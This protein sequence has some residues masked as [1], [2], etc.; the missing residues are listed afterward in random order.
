MKSYILFI[1]LLAPFCAG[2]Q[3]ND[4]IGFSK[5]YRYQGDM[6]KRADLITCLTYD[7]ADNDLFF[8][9]T[10]LNYDPGQWH[11]LTDCF[12]TDAEGHVLAEWVDSSSAYSIGYTAVAM[13]A[14]GQSV[15]WG[16]QRS[17]GYITMVLTKTDKN[18]N[19]IWQKTYPTTVT[20]GYNSSVIQDPKSGDIYMLESQWTDAGSNYPQADNKVY[21]IKTDSMGNLLAEGTPG[22][23]G[24]DN[25]ESMVRTDDGNFLVSGITWGAG[26]G[27]GQEGSPF[28]MKVD[29]EGN[30]LWHH[31]Y[32]ANDYTAWIMHNA[33]AGDGN[34]INVGAV[35]PVHSITSHSFYGNS[36][37]YVN[38]I[39]HSGQLVWEKDFGIYNIDD[40]LY[41]VTN[42]PHNNIIACGA[43]NPTDSSVSR[44]WIIRLDKDGNVKWSRQVGR[45]PPNEPE[46]LYNVVALKD[47]SFVAAGASAGL[48]NAGRLTQDGWLIRFDSNGCIY[49]DCHTM[50]ISEPA[51]AENNFNLYPNPSS[52]TFS[53]SRTS[54]FPK[55]TEV[56]LIDNQGRRIRKLSSP[57]GQ[58]KMTYNMDEGLSPGIYYLEVKIKAGF[59]RKKLTLIR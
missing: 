59:T 16:G 40:Y 30:E 54:P 5:L 46:V 35:V 19:V 28:S 20:N 56:V 42:A 43:V 38:K 37:G 23:G 26:W 22:S 58:T 41:G 4:T 21:F 32:A 27:A 34:T 15:F 9:M 49:P 57:E 17:A 52:G 51:T 14:D 24:Y 29:S 48:D 53:I 6:A 44:G 36:S 25:G 50:G 3:N 11:T 12:R 8:P 18:L 10:S 33:N 7:S 39:D 45:Y 1:L 2:A 31:L 13:S 47:G 55:G